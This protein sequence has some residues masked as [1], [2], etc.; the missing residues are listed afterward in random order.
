MVAL[1]V[2][3]NALRGDAKF[4]DLEE[5][6]TKANPCKAAESVL[7]G[8]T[9]A[10]FNGADVQLVDG[11]YILSNFAMCANINAEVTAEKLVTQRA[12]AAYIAICKQPKLLGLVQL[13]VSQ[14]QI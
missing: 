9:P 12:I 2:D 4:H 13:M 7:D 14:R 3:D 8:G 5:E 1:Q 10:K 11:N 6:R